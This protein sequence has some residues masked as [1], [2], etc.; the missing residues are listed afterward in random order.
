MNPNQYQY[1]YNHYK[2]EF[3]IFKKKLNKENKEN[4]IYQNNKYHCKIIIIINNQKNI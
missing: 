1:Q 3:R 2:K 4:K